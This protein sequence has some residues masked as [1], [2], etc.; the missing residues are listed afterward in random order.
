MI[1]LAQGLRRQFQAKRV[2][3]VALSLLLAWGVAW[4]LWRAGYSLYA[5]GLG[6][7]LS[8]LVSGLG[9]TM[10]ILV[11][12]EAGGLIVA[13]ALVTL[14]MSRNRVLGA[15]ATG[16]CYFF[17]GTP[18]L[19]QL[20]LV[21]Y[22]AAELRTELDAVGLWG[23]FRD[24]LPCVLFAFIL[25]T[26]AYKAE[27]LL[28]A[29]RSVPAGQVEAARALGLK[30][31]ALY[32]KVVLPQAVIVALRPLANETAKMVKASALASIVT[33]LDLLGVTKVI[34]ADT[35]D[36]DIYYVAAVV[37]LV[38]IEGLRAT[39]GII[40]SRLIRHLQVPALAGR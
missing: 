28:G 11:L 19:A 16:Y 38:F 29:I 7:H 30:P 36:F 20:Y 2:L 3:G 33:V 9:M 15:A 34:Y 12:S 17:R 18:L 40:E 31:L 6:H 25:N 10:L 35:F 22:G 14:R 26:A 21:Y 4:V 5:E 23:I 13:V 37:Y 1:G 32:W 24:A 8:F 27:V 39:V